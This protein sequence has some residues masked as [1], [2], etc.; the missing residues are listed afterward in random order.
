MV[1][2]LD[3]GGLLVAVAAGVLVV[4]DDDGVSFGVALGSAGSLDEL[5]ELLVLGAGDDVPNTGPPVR[6]GEP[7][8]VE[9]PV[10][11]GVPEDFVGLGDFEVG[12]GWVLLVDD[13]DDDTGGF[14]RGT[15][16]GAPG[17][18]VRV[19]GGTKEGTR[20]AWSRDVPEVRVGSMDHG[21]EGSVERGAADAGA[22]ATA[23][24]AAG[25]PQKPWV[26]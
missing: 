23:A 25:S 5:L 22:G 9:L 13:D 21:V 24:G 20:V 19:L 16:T 4:L 26:T 10:G 17:R 3:T 1:A 15:M 8:D 2:P 18:W 12:V 11:V 6:V 14:T 7:V